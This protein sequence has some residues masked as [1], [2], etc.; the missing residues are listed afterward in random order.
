LVKKELD[1]Y[2][3]HT[4]ID[5]CFL[6]NRYV[7]PPKYAKPWG[8]KNPPK[9]HYNCNL[10]KYNK[11]F[12]MGFTA[13]S[14][15]IDTP[16]VNEAELSSEEL[17]AEILWELTFYGWTEKRVNSHV[18]GIKTKISKAVKEIKLPP[19]KKGGYKIVIPDSVAKQIIDISNDETKH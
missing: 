12:A 9:G 2:D 5:V 19:Q 18:E 4:Y 7:A 8:G 10:S 1:W 11:V 6:N 16:I 15:L 13:W 14:K 17:A 3:N